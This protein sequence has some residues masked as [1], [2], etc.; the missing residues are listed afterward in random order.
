MF[1]NTQLIGWLLPAIV[2][3]L[4]LASCASPPEPVKDSGPLLFPTPPDPAR[5]VFERT[6][7]GT[8]SA[9]SQTDED[10]LRSLLTGTTVREGT[11]FSKPFD[12][13]NHSYTSEDT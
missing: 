3:A 11:G 7:L 12:A 9:R 13:I 10:R 6:I 1:K 5:F 4:L 2:L 8:G